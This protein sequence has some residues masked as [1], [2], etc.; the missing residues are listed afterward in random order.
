MQKMEPTF[1]RL[2]SE[3]FLF[4]FFF[5]VENNLYRNTKK[6]DQVWEIPFTHYILGD[7]VYWEVHTAKLFG[8]NMDLLLSK[9]PEWTEA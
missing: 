6:K 5:P 8:Y 7:P 2:K 1:K 3:I 4:N 9:N